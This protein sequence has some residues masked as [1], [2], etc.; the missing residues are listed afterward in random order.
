M[1]ADCIL[2][3]EDGDLVSLG[4][5]VPNERSVGFFETGSFS[6]TLSIFEEE[7]EGNKKDCVDDKA[8]N[9]VRPALY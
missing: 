3:F 7:K 5:A 8:R 6:L 2:A 1:N 9:Y 4:S